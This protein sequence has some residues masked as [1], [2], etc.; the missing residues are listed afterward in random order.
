MYRSKEVLTQFAKIA[1][2]D[3]PRHSL[4]D[5]I[6][7]IAKEEG[8]TPQQVEYVCSHAN[9][10]V[11]SRLFNMD[12][13]ASYDFPVADASTIIG[14]LKQ[15]KAAPRINEA[16][17]D[18]M[19]PPSLT[20]KT[21]TCAYIDETKEFNTLDKT[22]AEKRAIK[23]EL[24]SRME[25]M[26]LARDEFK[27]K[28][29]INASAAED[30]EISFVK[31]ARELL[32]P[33]PLGERVD[34]V[35][36]IAAFLQD[37]ASSNPKGVEYSRG[38]ITKLAYVLKKQG[39]IKESDLKAPAELIKEDLPARIINGRHPLYVTIKTLMDKY[40]YQREL[41]NRYRIVDD[42]L[43]MVREKIREL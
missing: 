25:K 20:T 22:A 37:V 19:T 36:K 39:L 40:D 35:T 18:Y 1:A 28:M 16:E 13:Q 32:I 23:F 42:T 9:Q 14:S 8:L 6:A 10:T 38:L 34:G 26:A 30:L 7:K 29:I 12:K 15:I 21:A 33:L 27:S 31:S 11:W 2:T 41:E 4:N 43:P 5:S 24:T 17:L 3:Y